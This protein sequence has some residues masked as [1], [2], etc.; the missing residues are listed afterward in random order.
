MG[1]GGFGGA[2]VLGKWSKWAGGDGVNL[3][4]GLVV[5]LGVMG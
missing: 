4:V 2:M 3:G 1:G 5:N